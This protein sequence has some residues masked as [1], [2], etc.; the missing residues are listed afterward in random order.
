MKNSITMEKSK[1]VLFYTNHFLRDEEMMGGVN[2]YLKSI[3]DPMLKKGIKAIIIERDPLG[4]QEISTESLL[5]YPLILDK[6]KN[7]F[8]GI[9]LKINK[10][11]IKLFPWAD[12]RL[13]NTINMLINSWAFSNQISKIPDL[14][15]VQVP[16]LESIGIFLPR[17]RNYQLIVRASSDRK[18]W[19]EENEIRPTL[20]S[21][22]VQK[23]EAR[24]YKKADKI[25]APSKYLANILT[26]NLKRPVDII[27]SPIHVNFLKWDFDFM[28]ENHLEDFQ[29]VLYFGVLSRR[30][31]IFNIAEAIRTCWEMGFD[32]KL[33]VIGHDIRTNGI[34]NLARMKDIIG[35]SFCNPNFI[36]FPTIK[37]SQLFPVIEKSK[38]VLMP[39]IIDNSPN[40]LLEV[41]E[42]GKI[43]IGTYDSG[44][45]EFY[46]PLCT[47]LL[48][49]KGDSISLS[50][51]IMQIDGYSDDE[52]LHLG[53]LLKENI[54]KTHNPERIIEQLTNLY[55]KNIYKI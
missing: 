14:D 4:L 33:V 26:K 6:K 31:G 51:K 7:R 8:K 47:D 2:I 13:D 11:F 49:K 32:K 20:D 21:R 18:L 17:K 38:F 35:D 19:D 12:L 23:L 40:S 52:L 22:M 3:V 10:V 34:S 16:N 55:E 45:D 50:Q 1:T 48:V 41:M 53:L 42:I 24:Q 46:S 37:H 25:F 5:V 30:K 36:F 29:Y 54:V 15:I 9:L 28:R 43:I 44:L 39:S 27:G